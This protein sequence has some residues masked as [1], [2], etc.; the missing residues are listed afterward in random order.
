MDN[1]S[2]K[3]ANHDLYGKISRV[4]KESDREINWSMCHSKMGVHRHQ[5]ECGGSITTDDDDDYDY[6]IISNNSEPTRFSSL[7]HTQQHSHVTFLV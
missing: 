5:T 7:L 6:M 1:Q 4:D 3:V 2:D